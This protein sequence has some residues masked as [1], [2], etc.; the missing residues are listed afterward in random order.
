MITY[1]ALVND[2]K[3]TFG[4]VKTDSKV[5]STQILFWVILAANR[6]RKDA[7]VK[8]DSGLYLS[9]YAPIPVLFDASLHNR[10][11]I[12]LPASIFD[13]PNEGSV[14]YITYFTDT[15]GCKGDAFAQ[16]FF[17]PTTAQKAWLLYKGKYTKPTN[18][19]P[20]FYRI[21]KVNGIIANRLYLLGVENVSIKDV[22]IQLL[23]A[24]DPLIQ[25]DIDEAIGLSDENISTL[26]YQVMALAKYS[27]MIPQERANTGSDEAGEKKLMNI[28]PEKTQSV[29]PQE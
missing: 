11:Y 14:K 4:E 20:F 25:V 10:K 8:N 16:V 29:Q 21:G 27:Y 3:I 18:K 17:Q 7:G 9:T 26:K 23:T 15:N 5:G 12:E 22:E 19:E 1:R 13:L 2:I 24:I 28:A 6:M